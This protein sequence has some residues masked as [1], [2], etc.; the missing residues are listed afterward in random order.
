[1]VEVNIG[2]GF[3]TI[4]LFSLLIITLF[5]GVPLAF[6]LGGTAVIFSLLFWSSNSLF[7]FAQQTFS[8]M[9]NVV[10][11]AVPSFIL[12]G[13]TLGESGV[14]EDLYA[15]AYRWLG[16]LRGG[17]A[18]GTVA[19]CAVFA[20]MS[21]G[22]AAGTVTMGIVAL[23]SMFKRNYKP[24]LAMGSVMG[25]G[26]LGILIPPSIP[27]II[28]GMVT[29]VSV[30]RLFIAGIVPGLL[31]VIMF[32]SYILVI[33]WVN[34]DQAPAIPVEEMG[35]LK[36]RLA[37][38]ISVILPLILIIIVL[39]SIYTGIATPTEASAVGAFGAFVIAAI[40]RKL[41]A[42]SIWKI[43]K[44]S[45][46]LTAMIMWIVLAGM[47]FSSVYQALG[48]NQLI[49]QLLKNISMEPWVIL[50]LMQVSFFILGMLM[51]V[52]G[53]IFI[54]M[55]IYFPIILLLGFDP[56]W[57]GVLFIVNMEMAY[58]TPPFGFNLFFIKAIVSDRGIG[59]GQIYRAAI[60]FIF[61]QALCLIIVMVFPEI[62]LWLPNMMLT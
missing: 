61:I 6:A 26:A 45:G 1:M 8:L 16:Q 19:I 53:I 56:L 31:L 42:H 38:L 33:S 39:G 17:L 18:I 48:A 62:V 15:T 41:N 36:V 25:G 34:R 44:E 54:T 14:A 43:L 5:A 37:S 47:C 22:S 28:Y 59:I 10:M 30:G 20:A 24:K 49:I 58:L 57:F 7:I 11:V 51:D 23:P 13:A 32:I 12:M 50:I 9:N 40:H 29:G 35:T 46:R 55:P 27:M 3:L 21:G 60:P 52:S 2:I 4:I